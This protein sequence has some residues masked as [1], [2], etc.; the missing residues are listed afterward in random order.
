MKTKLIVGAL[1]LGAVSLAWVAPAA[2]AQQEVKIG[3]LMPLSGPVAQV[4]LDGVAAMRAAVEIVNEGAD[5]PLPLA[6]SKGLSGLKGAKVRLI[7]ADHQGKPEVGQGEAERL[8]NQE[9]VHVMFGAYFSSVTAASSQVA[10][11]AGIPYVNGSSSQPALTQRGLKW[12][13]RTSPNDEHFSIVMFDFMKDFTKKTGKKIETAAIFH[14][15]T[16]FGTDSGRVQEKLAKDNNIKV[17][18]KIAYKAQTTALTAEVQRLKA[19]NADVFLPSSYTSDTFLFLRTAKELDYNPKLLLAQN[20]GYT[21]PTFISTM[22][23]D[24]EGAIT[25]SPYNADL[26]KRIP[27]IA[28]VNAIF[29]KHSNGRDLSDVPAR[30]FTAMM[31]LLDAINRAGSTEPEKIRVAL[32]QTNIPA[33]QLIVPYRGVKFGSDGQNELV[34]PILMQVQGGKYC[35]IYPFELAACE[36]KYP[37]PTWAEKK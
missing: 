11:R 23:K 30:E 9:K 21:D 35:T 22:G 29:K 15:D 13:F 7:V 37:A 28:K 26:D 6:K 2:H 14:E 36:L 24:A 17:L 31:T 20:A 19:A 10:E 18:E 1:A 16:A 33:D 3:V 5:L 8:I 4:G 27:M 25:R 34:R 12:F 32:T